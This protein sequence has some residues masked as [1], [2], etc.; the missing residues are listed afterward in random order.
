MTLPKDDPC[1]STI[2]EDNALLRDGIALL[3]AD[4]GI[5]VAA[6]VGNADDLLAAVAS[7]RPDVAIM[8]VRMPPTHTDEGIRAALA[9]RARAPGTA[10]WCFS[11]WVETGY[12]A[13]LLA[14]APGPRRLPAQG[15]D[16]RT[17]EFIDALRRVA[18]GGTA[19]DPE[20]VRA[21]ARRPG[22]RRRLARL[23]ARERE[24]LALLAEGRSNAAIADELHLADAASRSTSPRSSPSSTC[25]PTRADHRRVLAVLRY[26]DTTR[27]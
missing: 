27:D 18:A 21:T 13:E 3:L 1:A 15:P 9:I 5:E 22:R 2:A 11:Q 4:H 7:H 20:V 14:D 16:R 25:P 10:C 12:A 26:L 19:L 6:A 24:I 8:D 17:E 23:T